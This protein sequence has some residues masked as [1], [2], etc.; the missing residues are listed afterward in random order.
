M[1][2]W[3][4]SHGPQSNMILGRLTKEAVRNHENIR[5]RGEGGQGAAEGS[6]AANVGHNANASIN[7]YI[8]SIPAVQQAQ[9]L[10]SKV[11]SFGAP[12]AGIGREGGFSPGPAPPMPAIEAET[13]YRPPPSHMHRP[14]GGEADNYYQAVSGAP[15]PP[16][17]ASRPPTGAPSYGAA[18]SFP[19]AGESSYPGG[20]SGYPG[21]G[22]SGYPGGSSYPGQGGSSYPG[23]G[24]PSFPGASSY[25]GQSGGGY[26][27][28]P[29]PSGPPPMPG[30]H[31]GASTYP[32]QTGGGA[33]FPAAQGGYNPG[34]MSPPPGPPGMPGMPG[35][36]FP[37]E[38]GPPPFPGGPRGFPDAQPHHG[39]HGH[40]HHGPP[41][42]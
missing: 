16:N 10:Y 9:G 4:Q 29:A 27:D 35:P 38:G 20:G 26:G 32:A 14:P 2:K 28:F 17:V 7:S 23:Q 33:D 5:L 34:Y 18:P 30:Q 19:G 40:H 25:S 42:Y 12:G 21:Q 8:S 36:G 22:G 39:H 6:Y 41:R 11:S 13:T 15:P 1:Q 3:S 37:G 24:A 31:Y